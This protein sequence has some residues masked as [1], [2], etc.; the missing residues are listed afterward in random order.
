MHARHPKEVPVKHRG[1]IRSKRRTRA[2]WVE[3]V[4]Q[5]RR[6]GKTASAYA[7]ERGLHAGTLAAW[8]SKVRDAIP[9]SRESRKKQPVFV[10]LHVAA[11]RRDNGSV[12]G[13]VEIV[14]ANGRRVRVSGAFESDQ[15]ARVLAVVEGAWSC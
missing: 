1:R 3:E 10:P 7:A 12:G 11:P 14:L 6:S 13:E 5:W 15:L 4:R 9:V 2:E 8:A